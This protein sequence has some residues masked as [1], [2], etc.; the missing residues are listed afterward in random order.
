[1]WLNLIGLLVGHELPY[2][3]ILHC[4]RESAGLRSTSTNLPTVDGRLFLDQL[5]KEASG[6]RFI[7]RAKSVSG[8]QRGTGESTLSCVVL[9]Y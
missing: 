3:I 6:Q 9:I 8:G 4:L 2:S 7:L 5:L 1:M